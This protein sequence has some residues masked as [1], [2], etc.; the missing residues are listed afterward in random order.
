MRWVVLAS[1]YAILWFLAL[2]ILLP[3]GIKSREGNAPAELGGPDPG[4]PHEPRIGLK[5]LLATIAA[6]LV[7]FIFYALILMKVV[8]I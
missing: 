5:I 6:G 8:D 3:V 7:W 1:A 2:Q 4:A